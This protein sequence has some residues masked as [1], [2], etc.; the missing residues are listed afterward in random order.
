[1][2]LMVMHFCN[3]INDILNSVTSL[4]KACDVLHLMSGAYLMSVIR[5]ITWVSVERKEKSAELSTLL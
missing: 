5:G 2:M 4:A 3:N 1:M